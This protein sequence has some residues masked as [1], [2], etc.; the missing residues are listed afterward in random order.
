MEP[1]HYNVIFHAP[2]LYTP[3]MYCTCLIMIYQ[4]VPYFIYQIRRLLRYAV[5]IVD[6]TTGRSDGQPGKPGSRGQIT[7]PDRN[8]H[9]KHVP[10]LQSTRF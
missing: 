3:R 2:T 6:S 8:A 7:T 10:Y 4:D 1:S 9:V 5:Q